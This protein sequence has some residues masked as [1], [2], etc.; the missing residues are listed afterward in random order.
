MH[1]CASFGLAMNSE[2]AHR[3][4]EGENEPQ[5]PGAAAGARVQPDESTDPGDRQVECFD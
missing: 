3:P 4:S 5:P 2:K 1:Y